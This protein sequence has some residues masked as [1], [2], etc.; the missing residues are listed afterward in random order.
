[1]RLNAKMSE[2]LADANIPAAFFGLLSSDASAP[3]RIISVDGCVLLADQYEKAEHVR[4]ESFPDRTGFECF[5]NHLHFSYSRT[6]ESVLSC[7]TYA[8]SL[9]RA[10]AQHAD[11]RSFL[12][13]LSLGNDCT[14]RFHEVRKG[15][16]WVAEN[17][18]RYAEDAILLLPVEGKEIDADD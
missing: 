18:E 14:V 2:M 16:N 5:V 15:E 17:L 1:M 4:V 13:I 3:P 6:R 9:Q 7:L 8:V 11:G 10:L 12:V